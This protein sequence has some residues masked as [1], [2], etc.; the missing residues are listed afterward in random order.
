MKIFKSN[1]ILVAVEAVDLYG[2][3]PKS[4]TPT[5]WIFGVDLNVYLGKIPNNL[6]NVD[7]IDSTQINLEEL[8]IMPLLKFEQEVSGPSPAQ[9]HSAII[10]P[11]NA[12]KD[13]QKLVIDLI[14]EHNGGVDSF[15]GLFENSFNTHESFT[16]N[17]NSWVEFVE[18]NY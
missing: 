18:E 2:Y 8:P 12:D 6:I 3:F 5:D 7:T 14:I 1:N 16:S 9:I 15:R 17:I 4:I 10:N 11:E 13:R